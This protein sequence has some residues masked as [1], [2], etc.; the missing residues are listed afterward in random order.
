VEAKAGIGRVN[1]SQ[2]DY[3]GAIIAYQELTKLLP[4]NP[5]IYYNLGL[6]FKERGRK[7]EAQEAL[8][9]AYQLYQNKANSQGMQQVESLLEKL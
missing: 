8:K 3:M 9:Q 4:D 2:G 1:L 7:K 6:A 5:D